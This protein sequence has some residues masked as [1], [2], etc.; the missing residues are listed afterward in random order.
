VIVV[1]IFLDSNDQG[2]QEV[3]ITEVP[4]KSSFEMQSP[5]DE[6]FDGDDSVDYIRKEQG[7]AVFDL[8][9]DGIERG[10]GL[11]ESPE[12]VLSELIREGEN[13]NAVETFENSLKKLE[14]QIGDR[15]NGDGAAEKES[16][17][18][19]EWMV[20]VGSFSDL[21]NAE[22][23]VSQLTED[24]F[25]AVALERGDE[26]GRSYKVRVGPYKNKTD[27]S[28][29]LLEIEQKYTVSGFLIKVSP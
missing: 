19:V 25:K 10:N 17:V 7:S 24:S 13:V 29:T 8:N 14:M 23:L 27:A 11:E 5:S 26:N 16:Q 12:Q 6:L 20:Q 15:L 22:R 9:V 18:L 1:P 3:K 21:T 4:P 28:N 2:L